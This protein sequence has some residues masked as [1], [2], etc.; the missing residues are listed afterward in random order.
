[1]GWLY[2]SLSHFG[3]SFEFGQASRSWLVDRLAVADFSSRRDRSVSTWWE[4]GETKTNVVK[5]NLLPRAA[6]SSSAPS[7]PQKE[8]PDLTLAQ[9]LANS[10][11][12]A[13]F[14]NFLEENLAGPALP[15]REAVQEWQDR[16]KTAHVWDP[17]GLD[18]LKAEVS[19]L[20]M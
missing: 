16:F 18:K 13:D 19:S 6:P 15:F 2:D 10:S 7:V 17:K 5:S 12:R 14:E 11:Y 1:M 3:E 8:A 9:V 20:D 4:D